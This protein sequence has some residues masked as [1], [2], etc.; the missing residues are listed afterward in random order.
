V[1]PD[2]QR[3]GAL[4][5][6]EHQGRV[7]MLQ[8]RKEPLFG[9]WTAPGGKL[10]RHEDPRQAIGREI[11]EETGLCLRSARLQLVVS[12]LSPD[13]SYNWLLFV[14]RG[15]VDTDRLT[16]SQEGPVRWV[17][18]AELP[19][20]DMAAIDVQLLPFVYDDHRRYL[21]HIFFDRPPEGKI[22]RVDAFPKMKTCSPDRHDT[23]L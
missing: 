3:L 14:F 4:C 7:L 6:V 11:G 22:V 23:A 18:L 2:R 10:E 17:P 20:L 12:E 21:I 1:K 8:R 15:A 13:L 19:K 5:F 16:E 9:Y